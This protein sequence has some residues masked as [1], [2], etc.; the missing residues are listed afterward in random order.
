MCETALAHAPLA[1]TATASPKDAT[2][3]AT[4]QA[5]AVLRHHGLYLKPPT[6]ASKA[7]TAPCPGTCH[8]NVE[9]NK[10]VESHGTHIFNI[11]R[12]LISI[13]SICDFAYQ[14]PLYHFKR[15]PRTV[16]PCKHTGIATC[17][18]TESKTISY[19]TSERQGI[20]PQNTNVVHRFSVRF[21]LTPGCRFAPHPLAA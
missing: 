18:F 10:H 9:T 17:T 12:Y 14:R 21:L 19:V 16:E 20:L 15:E 13:R 8:N 11:S 6:G 7:S 3:A 4:P 1:T 2:T 5:D